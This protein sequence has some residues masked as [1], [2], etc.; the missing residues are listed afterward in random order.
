[1]QVTFSRQPRWQTHAVRSAMGLDLYEVHKPLCW[2]K[3][4]FVT[5]HNCLTLEVRF[6]M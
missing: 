4:R 1:M 6:G 5:I 2:S 3:V